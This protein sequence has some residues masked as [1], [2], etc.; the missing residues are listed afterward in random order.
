MTRILPVCLPASDVGFAE[1]VRRVLSQDRWD[2][3]SAE[4]IALMQA[5]LRQSYP[6]AT[7]L[8]HDGVWAGGQRRTVVLDVYRD[9]APGAAELE[10]RWAGAV[11]DRS[12]VAAYRLAT[13]ILG[14]G[15][16]AELVVERAFRE[17][18]W[19]VEAGLSVEAGGAAVEAAARRL[20]NDARLSA[21]PAPSAAR[22]IDAPER[23]ALAG[24]SVRQGA[25]RTVLTQAALA[26]L[27]AAQRGVLELGVLEDLKV[28]EIAERMQTTSAAV[29][30]LLREALL[31]VGSGVP[32]SSA[33]TLAH[34]RAA[35]RRWD[36]LPANDLARA[37]RGLVVAHAWLDYQVVSGA[38]EPQTAI[39]VTGAD[40]R[41]IAAS[42]NAG[43]ILGRPSLIG[44]RIDD[45]TAAYARPL[46]AE[47]WKMFV[48]NGS[49]HGDYDCDR[50]GQPP[51][52]IPF[53]G[54]WGRPL[55]DLQV[56]YL[57]S[58]AAVPAGVAASA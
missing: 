38:V 20:A 10:V 35:Q 29:H 13:R 47:L 36:Q 27:L 28:S 26:R 9:G 40:R 56:G 16:A 43:H 46:V 14:D 48:A 49:M 57:Q 23:P 30:T 18:R 32:P 12:G 42:A 37:E 34:W 25:V 55:P 44:L 8:S 39:L 41:F 21:Q 6:M 31:A 50:P 17:V 33:T 19:S 1:R 22:T 45:V 4:A 58:L 51:I 15:A 53:R 5:V 2:L 3:D 11:Y 52:R 54:V 24:E 7:V